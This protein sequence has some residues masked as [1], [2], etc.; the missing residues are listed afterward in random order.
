MTVAT[1][2]VYGLEVA[3]S[4][5]LADKTSV[6]PVLDLL[7][8]IGR[9]S[10]V[11]EKVYTRHE[12]EFL[13]LKWP[14]KQY[15]KYRIGYLAG[16]GSAGS[17]SF[18]GGASLTL[19]DLAEILDGRLQGK[20]V[21]FG[22]CSVFDVDPEELDEFRARTKARAVAGYRQDVD[23][24]EAAAFELLLMRSLAE[25]TRVDA[26]DRDLQ[27]AAPGLYERLGFEMHY[28]RS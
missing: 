22:G 21:Y 7:D 20:V 1:P 23:W 19:I 5:Q 3:W 2:R 27:R 6:G 11:H 26:A 4:S 10:Y 17:L 12:F 25:R 18:P 9:V 16:H 13:L 24:F 15:A 8:R 28:G 14:Q